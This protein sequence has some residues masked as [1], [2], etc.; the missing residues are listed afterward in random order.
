MLASGFI[1]LTEICCLTFS[2]WLAGILDFRA[3]SHWYITQIDF[4]FKIEMIKKK[5]QNNPV[6]YVPGIYNSVFCYGQG[7][8]DLTGNEA[9]WGRGEQLLHSNI[10][11]PVAGFLFLFLRY[12]DALSR[13]EELRFSDVS[14]DFR[15]WLFPVLHI[16]SFFYSQVFPHWGPA[17]C[18]ET[19]FTAAMLVT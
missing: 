16:F 17:R 9:L 14:L 5:D 11:R 1:Q 15:V 2:F 18:M 10:R 6:S 8:R 13:G 19:V 3:S 7:H 4:P 12:W